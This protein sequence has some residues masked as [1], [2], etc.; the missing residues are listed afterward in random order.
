M[1]ISKN[2]N[3]SKKIKFLI[4]ELLSTRFNVL[5]SKSQRTLFKMEIPRRKKAQ[6]QPERAHNGIT[7]DGAHLFLDVS[8]WL[9]GVFSF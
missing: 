6:I 2:T 1:K 5:T 9:Q 3:Y 4:S 8:I 7:A